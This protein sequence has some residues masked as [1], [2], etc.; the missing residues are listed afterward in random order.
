MLVVALLLHTDYVADVTAA[1]AKANI[2]PLKDFDPL[3]PSLLRDP[4]HATLTTTERI[5]KCIE[6]RQARLVRALKHIR[7]TVRPAVGRAFYKNDW[8]TLDQYIEAVPRS[9]RSPENQL[10]FYGYLLLFFKIVFVKLF[11]IFKILPKL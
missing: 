6:V 11:F 3:D 4:K 9:T 5:T 10:I 7:E 1:F 2:E 8:I